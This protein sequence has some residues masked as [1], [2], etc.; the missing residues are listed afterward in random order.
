[1]SYTLNILLKF[2][3][4]NKITLNKEYLITDKIKRETRI[5]G[6]CISCQNSFDISFRYF[7][8]GSFRCK[9]CAN[10]IKQTKSKATCLE[11][12]GYDSAFQSAEVKNKSKATCLEKY[13]HEFSSQSQIIKDKKIATCLEKIGYENLQSPEMSYNLNRL[14]KYCD[15]NKI[16][17]QKEYLITDKIIPETRIIGKCIS[18]KNSFDSSFRLF[19]EGSFRCK[20]CVNIIKQTKRKSTCLEKYG[21]EN[22]AQSPEVKIKSKATCLEKY[23]CEFSFQSQVIQ[24]KCKVTYLEK[25]GVENPSQS[26]AIKD[27]KIATCLKNFSVENPSQSQAIKDKKIATCLENF[28]VEYSFQSPEVQD[29]SKA[30]CLKK[31]NCENPSQC[32]EVKDKK[33]TTSL[34]NY[35]VENPM[36]NADFME[37]VSKNAYKLK[38][39][40][41]PSGNTRK[42]QGY[43]NFALDELINNQNISEDDIITGAKNVPE[44]WYCDKE[45]KKHRYYVDIFIKSQNRMIEVKSTWTAEKKKDCILLKQA[46]CKLADYKCEIWVY[47]NKREKTIL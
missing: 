32:Q 18:C 9:S 43:E 11:K 34:K 35:G 17:L 47:N 31:F 37:K 22:P 5:I 2:C 33:I 38:S 23:G 4:E 16:T 21:V 45:G 1:M 3:D 44:I 25:F 29:K 39:Y 12:Y 42:Y 13:G 46:A 24:D 36:Q 26:Q 14:L 41:F 15:E 28:N 8:E 30:T 27:K 7:I 19:I 20:S 6:K 10:I 40:I